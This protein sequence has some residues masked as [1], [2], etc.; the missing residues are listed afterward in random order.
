MADEV[1]QGNVYQD[2]VPFTSMYKT[3]FT[4]PPPLTEMLELI[5][6]HSASKVLH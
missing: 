2:E 5:S 1:Y 3:L 6:F 4:L